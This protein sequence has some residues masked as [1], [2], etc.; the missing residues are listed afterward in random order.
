VNESPASAAL[1]PDPLFQALVNCASDVLAVVSEKGVLRFVNAS[2]QTMTGY[3]DAVGR[4][5]RTLIHPDDLADVEQNFR[6]VVEQTDF[7]ISF[8]HR[9]RHADG[10]WIWLET[11]ATNALADSAIQGLVLCSRPIGERR[12]AEEALRIGEERYRDLFEKATD[13]LFTFSGDGTFTSANRA[14]GNL[15]GVPAEELIGRPVF[16][17]LDDEELPRVIRWLSGEMPTPNTRRLVEIEVTTRSG[18]RIPLEISF[19]P[20]GNQSG[21]GSVQ[22][23]A[24]DVTQQR[25]L[26]SQQ[27][28]ARDAALEAA[29]AKSEFLANLSHELRTPLNAI[30]GM[31]ALLAETPLNHEQNEFLNVVTG[32][33]ESLLALIDDLLDFSRLDTGRVT[34]AFAPFDVRGLV[35]EVARRFEAR[36]KAKGLTF[37]HLVQTE[38]PFEMQGDAARIQQIL[39]HLLG[40]AVKFTEQGEIILRV[41]P[42]DSGEGIVFEVSDTGIGIEPSLLPKLFYPFTQADGSARRSY[43][44]I[45]VGLAICKQLAELMGGGMSAVSEPG[46]GSSFRFT[47]PQ[48]TAADPTASTQLP[49]NRKHSVL[50]NAFGPEDSGVLREIVTAYLIDTRQHLDDLERTIGQPDPARLRSIGHYLKGSSANIGASRLAALSSRL[51]ALG[52]GGDLSCLA[53]L[54]SDIRTEFSFVAKWLCEEFDLP[55]P[56]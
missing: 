39:G 41:R 7:P 15:L 13:S 31:S 24:R 1:S 56:E 47:L 3:T 52:G 26:M 49:V 54:F 34:V 14:C 21:L 35:A 23:I 29:R 36:I 30:I 19:R 50:L 2:F 12:A 55:L 25:R 11:I 53:K 38:V 6:A 9:L 42:D 51:E 5:V 17:F 48:I 32:A 20:L 8:E 4:N 28:A 46:K 22:C 33:S 18:Q 44:G 16:D 45:G 10:S 37:V 27:A 43:G 40:N